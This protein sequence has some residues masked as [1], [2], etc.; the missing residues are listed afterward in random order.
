MPFR[1]KKKIL[2]KIES[3]YIQLFADFTRC[4]AA[5]TRTTNPD[6]SGDNNAYRETQLSSTELEML[7]MN[8]EIQEQSAPKLVVTGSK[9]I[10]VFND[11]AVSSQ[12]LTDFISG[13]GNPPAF[14]RSKNFL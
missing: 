11:L 4:C 3:D 5:H 8:V 7:Y 1:Y 12:F 14:T 2:S 10:S 13:F 6:S 9:K